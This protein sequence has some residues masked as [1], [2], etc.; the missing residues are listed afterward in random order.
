MVERGWKGDG[1]GM[2]RGWKGDG[3][4]WK[5]VR[6]KKKEDKKM[7]KKEKEKE[8]EEKKNPINKSIEG[9]KKKKT[10]CLD[11]HHFVLASSSRTSYDPNTLSQ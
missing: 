2:E 6:E 9:K 11:L 7:K 8:E 1:K 4:G 10:H 3:K 5:G